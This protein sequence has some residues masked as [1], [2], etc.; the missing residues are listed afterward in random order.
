MFYISQHSRNPTNPKF[1]A[2][3]DNKHIEK[4]FS[5]FVLFIAVATI[6][7][8]K[9]FITTEFYDGGI[10]ITFGNPKIFKNWKCKPETPKT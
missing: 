10:L 1:E 3:S 6:A 4:H 8:R 5:V 7:S 2:L 9:V